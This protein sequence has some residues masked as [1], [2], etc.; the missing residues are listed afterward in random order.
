MARDAPP[1]AVPA[2]SASPDAPPKVPPLIALRTLAQVWRFVQPYRRQVI[3]AAISLVVAASAVLTIGQGLKFVIDQ[4]IAA[5]SEICQSSS[6]RPAPILR[7]D[8]MMA[9]STDCNPAKVAVT[10]GKIASS[11]TIVILDVS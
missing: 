3:Y 6:L 4:G 11:T 9:R 10:T 8:Q 5:G 2:S 1:A 7:A